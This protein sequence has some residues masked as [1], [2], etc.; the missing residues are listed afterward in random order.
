MNTTDSF[1]SNRAPPT[2]SASPPPDCALTVTQS[3]LVSISLKPVPQNSSPDSPAGLA[4]YCSTI[5]GADPSSLSIPEFPRWQAH[6]KNLSLPTLTPSDF[7]QKHVALH[8]SQA[9]LWGDSAT[10][11]VEASDMSFLGPMILEKKE[12][13]QGRF[14]NQMWS[15]YELTS[16]KNSLQPCADEQYTK[17]PQTGWNTEGK[18][19]QLPISQ[20]LLYIKLLGE[21][22][23]QNYSQLFWGLPSLHSESL[24]ATLL[25]S[26]SYSPLDCPF[27]LF[28]G[29][30]KTPTVQMKDKVSSPLPKTQPLP[31]PNVELLPLP[32]T[33]A[34]LQ[35]LHLTQVQPQ[36]H[37][38]SPIPILPSYSPPQIR[39]CG[40]S[41]H[42]ALNDVQSLIPTAI[43]HLEW[44]LLQKQQ[45]N[46]WDLAP[47]LQ[48]SQETFC[49][50]AANIPLSCQSSEVYVPTSILPQPFPRSRKPQEEL[51]FN[52]PKRLIPNK[53]L[54]ASRSQQSL[55]MQPQ[56]KLTEKSQQKC[57]RELP[58]FS[59]FLGQSSSNLAKIE[60]SQRGSFHEEVSSKCHLRKDM[61]KNLGHSLREGPKDN[62]SQFSEKYIVKGP[63]AAFEKETVSDCISHSRK[64]SGNELLT[65]SRDYIDE[66][67]RKSILQCHLWKKFWQIT[68][69]R[70]PLAVC[71][72]WLADINTSPPPECSHINMEDRNLDP[73]VAGD[74]H[75]TT[76]LQLS[77][78]DLNTQE[79][80]EDHLLRFQLSQ[81]WGLP[82]KV[83][84]SVKFYAL[85][86]AQPWALPQINFPSSATLISGV[87]SK[88]KISK[89]F[90]R[91]TQ[92]FQGDEVLT[93]IS[94]PILDHSLPATSSVGMKG[95]GA[96]RQS[97]SDI[98]HELV[99]DFQTAEDG[100]QMFLPFTYSTVDNMCQSE[101]VTAK[102]HSPE[103][104][105]SQDRAGYQ[106]R[107][108]PVSSSNR[109]EMLQD[110]RMLDIKLKHFLWANVSREIFK[111]RELCALE[112]QSS[113]IWTTSELGKSRMKNVDMSKLETTLITE[114][115]PL[116][117]ISVSQDPKLSYLQ[118]QLIN[119]LKF[120]FER[121]EPSQAQDCPT[122]LSLTSDSLSSKSLVSKVLCAQLEDRAISMEQ[123]QQP[124]FPI[125]VSGMCQDK[126]FPPAA[127]R[128]KLQGPKA[129]EYGRENSGLGTSK[130]RWKSH[131]T[132]SRIPEEMLWKMSS[133]SL[134]QKE[135]SPPESCFRK[136][137]R[138]FLQWLH[139]K[140]K[141]LR[142][143]SSLQKA[144][145]MLAS[146]KRLRPVENKAVLM[147]CGTPEAQKL[148]TA[149][150]N[151]LEEKLR[152][153]HGLQAS[154]L[155]QQEAELQEQTKLEV[156]PSS[157]YRIPFC[158]VSG[159]D[160]SSQ[161]SVSAGSSRPTRVRRIRGR[162]RHPQNVL[163]FE[164]QLLCQSYPP[165]MALREPESPSSPTCMS[166]EC[167]VP[168]AVFPTAEASSW[169]SET[170][171]GTKDDGR[172][173]RRG[174]PAQR[175]LG[176]GAT[177]AHPRPGVGTEGAT[178][179]LRG[180][181]SGKR[182]PFRPL[183]YVTASGRQ[184]LRFV[185]KTALAKV[186]GCLSYVCSAP[187]EG[188]CG[189][190]TLGL[191]PPPP[192]RGPDLRRCSDLAS[193]LGLL[194]MGPSSAGI[195][196]GSNSTSAEGGLRHV[197][198][199][200]QPSRE[201]LDHWAVKGRS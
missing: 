75:P 154:A 16:S 2:L 175:A 31:L 99:E 170:S 72:S 132:Q 47:V 103:L 147:S 150:G 128:R 65:V 58:Q 87:N 4:A 192:L 166:Q 90:R 134:A 122:D 200:R 153:S 83:L 78:L 126:N 161:E 104:L 133:L 102:R 151:M 50:S 52:V 177:A 125:H 49:L 13:D 59:E 174:G 131:P 186:F 28:N 42:R 196:G 129:G 23:L 165:S 41:F 19:E 194:E 101:T 176:G 60:L 11:H 152:C 38:Q 17:A 29:I 22:F 168:Q 148:M 54:L 156:G 135:Q 167:Q 124:W 107:D 106:P 97:P 21:N 69:D 43:P 197:T 94:V 130:V 180:G 144:K 119:E 45:E 86:K 8:L 92:A 20:H 105:A 108:Q 158:E 48:Q 110:K 82:L 155:S 173:F 18:P 34:Q 146:V 193:E 187:P 96:K 80:L 188:F 178:V 98:D 26:G 117:R 114:C 115:P 198:S 85:R 195:Q 138:Q 51:E 118:K 121:K 62:S 142:L 160:T 66:N 145:S 190:F 95:Q 70:I 111:A 140:C 162:E 199:L 182:L 141:S 120:K 9:C 136:L 184:K 37:L 163:G 40:V 71:R 14:P 57:S 25:V 159:T 1:A 73:L 3:Q 137:I 183:D 181:V 27:V 53:S 33:Q 79:V 77:F 64:D 39:S 76:T 91:H 55:E 7:Q 35:P 63:G 84:E 139:S 169:C 10:K 157:S 164:D 113:N 89:T 68:E 36:V 149:I 179:W 6:A 112:S 12:K 100:R 123:G 143:G 172:D 81:R 201:A 191:H 32:P 24:V 46:L 61:G 127:K 5:T 30:C 15:E 88:A 74:Y 56:C 67:K 44:H 116:P 185:S 109:V 171:G 189:P 93:T